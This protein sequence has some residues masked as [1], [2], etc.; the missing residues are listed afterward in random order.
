MQPVHSEFRSKSAGT[1]KNV[2]LSIGLSLLE[3]VKLVG[4]NRYHILRKI[5]S[6]IIIHIQ[7]DEWLKPIH[8]DKHLYQSELSK[9][10]KRL[11]KAFLQCFMYNVFI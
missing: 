11:N 8:C 2:L 5:S 4:G 10:Q 9:L 7:S 3:T 6:I 1:L